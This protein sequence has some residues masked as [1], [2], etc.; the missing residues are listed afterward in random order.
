MRVRIVKVAAHLIEAGMKQGDVV[1]II[2]SNSENL[3]PIVFACFTL[4]LPINT[5]ALVMIES[6]IIHMYSKTKPKIIFSDA[7]II[8]TLQNAID[9]MEIN[10]TIY[11]FI[12]KVEG[13]KFVDEI[14]EADYNVDEFV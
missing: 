14:F 9:S 4:G 13:I 10:P 11:T 2:A 12:N 8:S 1:G 6:D 3:A 7:T 5:L